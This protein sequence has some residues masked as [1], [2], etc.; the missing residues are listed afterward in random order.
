[1]VSICRLFSPFFTS[2]VASVV[3]I[4]SW[5]DIPL[6]FR[7]VPG[8]FLKRPGVATR[9]SLISVLGLA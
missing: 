9:A 6:S 3:M 4:R 2:N 1:M 5:I 8:I 7:S